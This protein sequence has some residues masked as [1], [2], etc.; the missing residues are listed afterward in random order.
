MEK[1]SRPPYQVLV[2]IIC[3]YLHHYELIVKYVTIECSTTFT[4]IYRYEM[5]IKGKVRLA[6]IDSIIDY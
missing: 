3:I 6:I 5:I 1:T 2:E 4:K